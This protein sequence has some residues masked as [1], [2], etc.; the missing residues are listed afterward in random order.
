M[1]HTLSEALRD[2]L[3]R[4][5]AEAGAF[6]TAGNRA[7]AAR[8][9]REALQ[10]FPPPVHQWPGAIRVFLGLAEV[11]RQ[12]GDAPAA[13]RVLDDALWCAGA[14]NNPLL[15]LR[16]GQVRHELGDTTSAQEAL[17]RA[18]SIEPM[19]FFQ[20]DPAWQER[21]QAALWAVTDRARGATY[22]QVRSEVPR[23]AD[24]PSAANPPVA[25]KGGTLVAHSPSAAPPSKPGAP[26]SGDARAALSAM[27]TARGAAAPKTPI[28]SP[29]TTDPA[30]T[31]ERSFVR[32]AG[33]NEG[34][35]SRAP[36]TVTRVA[37][38]PSPATA[39]PAAT[40]VARVPPPV[41][42]ATQRAF[43]LIEIVFGAVF[44]M[45][46]GWAIV[47]HAPGDHQIHIGIAGAL[48]G[49]CAIALGV[50][51]I[52]ARARAGRFARAYPDEPWRWRPEWTAGGPIFSREHLRAAA[53]I[54][55]ALLCA[56]AFALF[57]GGALAEAVRIDRSFASGHWRSKADTAMSFLY[58]FGALAGASALAAALLSRRRKRFARYRLEL[59]SMP[60]LRGQA[61]AGSVIAQG[62]PPAHARLH[63]FVRFESAA[64]PDAPKTPTRVAEEA[65]TFRAVGQD[66][67]RARFS[68]HV[69]QDAPPYAP[70]HAPLP[71]EWTLVLLASEGDEVVAKRW[72]FEIP[73]V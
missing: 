59:A 23:A 25:A 15:L 31:N 26:P 4:R 14:E 65:L 72:H 67:R 68:L 10:L 27:P 39:N 34:V 7:E 1:Q 8:I 55:A 24:A 48:A 30:G 42:D 51:S 11:L 35:P 40:P 47:T 41:A 46:G 57:A 16:L 2:E 9:Y 60:A 3:E 29:P 21:A 73:V 19:I 28:A 49:L 66:E 69:P 17:A 13:H 70:P 50:R 56:A 5:C 44:A 38:P 33:A 45:G 20:E 12:G 61:V 64:R 6:A 58:V 37:A 22:S 32:A 54:H 53:P 43:E 36:A 71:T 62:E 63:L 18:Y 52:K